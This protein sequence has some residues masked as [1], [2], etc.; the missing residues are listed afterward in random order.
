MASDLGS[1]TEIE[2]LAVYAPREPSCPLELHAAT[3][4][5]R[6]KGATAGCDWFLAILVLTTNSAPERLPAAS[7]VW[8]N[9]SSA[10]ALDL[11][12]LQSTGEAAA[13]QA[14]RRYRLL[15]LD[16]GFVNRERSARGSPVC[17]VS[18]SVNAHAEI[19]RAPTTTKPP[20]ASAVTTGIELHPVCT[21]YL[22][23]TPGLAAGRIEPLG[24]YAPALFQRRPETAL[25][26][27]C[28]RGN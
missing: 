2:T 15:S 1:G 11:T 12:E 24:V 7:N 9:T 8:P 22:Q 13:E 16:R 25:C 5:R 26:K 28:S 17:P 4:P 19:I 14:R 3:K 21:D 18:L 6:P 27:R 20:L 10:A 23:R